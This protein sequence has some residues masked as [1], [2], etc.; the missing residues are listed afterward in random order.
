MSG[1][2]HTLVALPPGRETAIPFKQQTG[3]EALEWRRISCRWPLIEPR[4]LGYP[5]RSLATVLIELSQ[6]NFQM[7][8]HI[9]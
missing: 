3:L 6:L 9:I 1:Q 5:V 7:S 8:F 4:L 2:L